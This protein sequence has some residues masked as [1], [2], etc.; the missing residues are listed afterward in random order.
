MPDTQSHASRPLETAVMF[1]AGGDPA[2][3][4]AELTALGIRSGQLGIPG[5]LDMSCA[6]QWR[7]ALSA[8]GFTVF[9]VFAAY[10]GESYADIPTVQSTVGF[11]PPAT[12]DA[13]ERRTLAVSD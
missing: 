11:V 9:T 10:D 7:D 2:Q 3:T 4:I 5:D 8:A 13:R 1:W 12:R 6:P